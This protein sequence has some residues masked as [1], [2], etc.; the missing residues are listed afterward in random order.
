MVLALM[1]LWPNK[2]PPMSF[3]STEHLTK[4]VWGFVEP[5]MGRKM[6]KSARNFPRRSNFALC[7]LVLESLNELLW[8]I[9]MSSRRKH[10]NRTWYLFRRLS[11]TWTIFWI[12]N[13]WFSS[14]SRFPGRF[15][16]LVT[17]PELR[18]E[19]GVGPWV[20]QFCMKTMRQESHSLYNSGGLPLFNFVLVRSESYKA[21]DLVSPR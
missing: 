7:K 19:R 20:I 17:K 21:H 2:L 4:T 1:A 16:A 11:N 5:W 18:L 6:A 9:S 12:R 8:R 3:F 13:R 14:G 10:W 15:A